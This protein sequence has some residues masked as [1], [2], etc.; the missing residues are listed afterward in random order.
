MGDD[1]KERRKYPRFD[2]EYRT[3][4]I[5]Q[6]GDMVITG[7]TTNISDGGLRLPMPVEC[8]P[9]CGMETQVNLSIQRESN[10]NVEIFNGFGKVIRHTSVDE[11]GVA[12]IVIIFFDP[13]DLRL[14]EESC[15][16]TF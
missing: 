2:L 6:N 10:G 7:L 12:E 15:L 4:L 11:D 13:I 9:E 1:L 5:S 3:Q 8:L 14:Q 16:I